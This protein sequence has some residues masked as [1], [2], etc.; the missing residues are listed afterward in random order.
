[1]LLD[2]QHTASAEEEGASLELNLRKVY[3]FALTAPLDDIR[4]ILDCA[5]LNK[6]AAEQAF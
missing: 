3:D 6:A 5:R 2:K 4:F 1:M